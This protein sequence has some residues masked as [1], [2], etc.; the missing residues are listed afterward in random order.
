MASFQDASIG[1]VPEVTFGTPVTPMTR[2]LEYVSESFDF[3]K[4][5]KQGQGLRV[6]SR[7]GRSARRVVVTSDAGGDVVIEATSKGMGTW[8]Q[9]LIGSAT[10]TLVSGTMYQ[11]VFTLADVMPMFTLQRGLPRVD[12]TVA[13]HTFSGCTASSVEFD[14][15]NADLVKIKATIDARSLSTVAAYTTPT[16]A[17][18]ATLFSFAGA[19]I[20]TGA[21]TAPTTT[22]LASSPTSLAMVRGGSVKIDHKLKGDR[23]N[24]GAAGLKSRQPVGLRDIS[25]KLTIEHDNTFDFVGAIQNQT[26][27]N[28]IFTWVTTVVLSAGV[29]TLQLVIPEVKLDGSLPQTNGTDLITHDVTFQGLDNL[30]AAQPVWVVIH[31]SDS[32]L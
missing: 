6:G 15:T 26:P 22:T 30:T 8:L 9:N 18:G 1:F 16:Y 13:A 12:G 31:T 29:E 19:T 2:W 32:A 14:F 24:A 5:I 23:Y 3:N 11:Q 20:T 21:L 10:S 27:M 25:G 17:S 7:V 28:L 4:V